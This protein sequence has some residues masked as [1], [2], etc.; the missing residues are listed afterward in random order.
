MVDRR[1]TKELD[2]QMQKL[3][4]PNPPMPANTQWIKIC[5]LLKAHGLIYS[6]N[7]HPSELLVHPENRNRMGLSYH[8][9][10]KNGDKVVQ[11]GAD[12]QQLSKASLV[13]WV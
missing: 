9:V 5:E 1:I 4:H 7:L 12:L 2:E 8:N 11:A 10:H 13:V 6:A 3:L